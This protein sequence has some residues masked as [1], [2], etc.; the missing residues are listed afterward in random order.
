MNAP[1]ARPRRSWIAPAAL[2]V[3]LVSLAANAAL[4]WK[5]RQPERL[6]APALGR[7]LR[8]L[9]EQDARLR[10]EV[11]LP[12]GTPLHFDIP[13]DESY[14]VRLNTTLPINTTVT[15]PVRSPLGSYDVRVPVRADV[16]IHTVLPVRLR[17]TFRL[18]TE[19]QAEIV[20]PLQVRV[21][22]LPLDAIE[23]SLNP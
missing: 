4:L 2:A 18:R 8:R 5:V 1:P 13:I 6:V 11:R 7:V 10:Y 19:T 12:A 16:P 15:L 21:R 3:A 14:E 9:A 23:K 22:D 17:D 20:V